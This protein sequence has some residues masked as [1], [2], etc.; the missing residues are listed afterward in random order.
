MLSEAITISELIGD[1]YQTA[2]AKGWWAGDRNFGEQLMLM[3]SELSEAMEEYRI[4]GTNNSK[5]LRIED[6]KPEGI[7]AEFADVLIRL[8]DTCG[9]YNIPIEEA[10]RLKAEYNTTRP[11]RH[12]GKLA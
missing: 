7:A 10:I 5:F 2:K 9:K 12:G 6:G 1:S 8:A 11:Y 3:V 4:H